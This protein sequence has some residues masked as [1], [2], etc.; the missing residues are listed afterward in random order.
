MTT[1]YKHSAGGVIFS[2]GRV[3]TIDWQTKSSIEFPKGGIEPDESPEKA[4]LRE[5]KEE[6]GYRAQIVAPL[7]SISYEYDELN[8]HYHKRVDYFL[9]EILAGDETEPKPKRE[10]GENFQDLW[11]SVRQ[12]MRRLTHDDS[13]V[14]LQRAVDVLNLIGDENQRTVAYVDQIIQHMIDSPDFVS[15]I[16]GCMTNRH[17]GLAMRAADG[18]EKFSLQHTTGLQPF[19]DDLIEILQNQSQKE[20]RWHLAQILPRLKL[21]DEQMRIVLKIWIEDFYKSPSNIV[22]AMSLQAVH[23]IADV[24]VPA[25][26]K[27]NQLIDDALEKGAPAIKARAR[28]LR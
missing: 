26:K 14:I 15:V 7:G 9:M 12:A 16:I 1:F 28:R 27:L 8:R 13:R 24:Y 10:P 4:A 17:R 6:T 21:S 25:G 11:L 18:L 19:A 23:D 20:V 3:L 2:H 5:V 22:Q